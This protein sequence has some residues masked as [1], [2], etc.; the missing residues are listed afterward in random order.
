MDLR[1]EK[2]ALDEAIAEARQR[3]LQELP[4]GGRL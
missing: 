4:R 3:E 1:G 2:A